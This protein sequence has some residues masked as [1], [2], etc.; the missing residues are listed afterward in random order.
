MTAGTHS[1]R[2]SAI[3][4]VGL[5][6]ASV[7]VFQALG[8]GRESVS[9][10]NST[11]GSSEGSPTGLTVFGEQDRSS[12]PPLEGLTLDGD[13]LNRRDF[14]GHVVVLNVWVWSLPGRGCRSHQRGRRELQQWR[15]LSW[16]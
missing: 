14:L 16:H 13:Q 11:S 4:A 7:G 10:G 5:L 15:P 1:R 8:A 6:L 2:P 3:L 12:A 9:T